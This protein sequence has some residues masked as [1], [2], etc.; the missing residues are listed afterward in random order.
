VGE[1]TA[2]ILAK[3]YKTIEAFLE[4]KAYD[5]LSINGLGE[6]VQHSLVHYKPEIHVPRILQY[7]TIIPYE[8]IKGVLSGK[9]IVFTGTLLSMSRGEAKD[10]AKKMGAQ[11]ASSVGKNTDIVVCGADAGSKYTKAREL[12]ITIWS[13]DEW[14]KKLR[15]TE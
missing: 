11:V 15:D 2:Q 5:I 7:M 9:V 10:K 1:I 3:H 6:N 4:D 8:E 13:E 14:V 12:G